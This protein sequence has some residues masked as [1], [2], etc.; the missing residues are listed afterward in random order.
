[1]V[2]LL[3]SREVSSSNKVRIIALYILHRDGVPDEDRRRLYQHA[4]LSMAEQDAVNALVYLGV[5]ISRGPGDRDVKRK[6]KAKPSTD[7]EYELSR[8]KPLLRT[9]IEDHNNGRLDATLFPY[10]K[11][12]PLSNAGATA[13]PAPPP[14]TTSLRSAKANWNKNPRANTLSDTR[15]RL[16][17]FIAG[18]MTYSEMRETYQLSASLGKEVI[19]GSTHAIT[20]RAFVDDLKVLELGGVGSRAVP[21]GVR[22][23]GG[24]RPYQA[25]YDQYYFLKDAPPKARAP[26]PQQQP[27][28]S[29]LGL[30]RP[31]AVSQSSSYAGS[32]TSAHTPGASS[33]EEKEKKKKRLFGRF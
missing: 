3:D 18:G 11:D 29:R 20:P 10:V 30:P 1:M 25:F 33:G 5:R 13:R 14:Q 26:P 12:A 27:E 19:V 2:P 23:P 15:Q 9:V 16:L 22:D 24:K 31:A 7:E 28:R 17:V 8:Y 32:T 21:N 4:R 6:L